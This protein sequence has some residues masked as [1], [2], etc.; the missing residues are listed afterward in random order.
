MNHVTSC[1]GC[2]HGLVPLLSA[3]GRAEPSCLWC[4]GLDVRT[5]DIAKWADSPTG[6]PERAARQ[7]FE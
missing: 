2:G 6:R 3:K 7:P 5:M 4:E 1:S